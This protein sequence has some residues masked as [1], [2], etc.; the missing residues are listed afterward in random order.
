MKNI[1]ILGSS[2]MAGHVITKYLEE[3]NYN[4][5]GLSR[6]K[7][8][9]KNTIFI[10]LLNI[11]DFDKFLNENKFDFIINCAGILNQ[12]A[13]NKPDEAIFINSYVPRFLEKKY[14]NSTTKII[15]ISTD[16]V[17]SG[18]KG[19]YKEED[20]KDGDTIYARTKSLGELNNTKD[21]T[22]RTSIIGPD[23]N[24]NG[25]GLFNWFMHQKGKIKG[26]K[27]A[28]WTGIT[29]IEFAKSIEKALSQD[30]TGIYHL[31]PKNKINKFDLLNLINQIFEKNIEIEEDFNY[32]VDKSL[33][34]TR[35]DFDFEILDYDQMIKEMKIWIKN[36][37]EL[38]NY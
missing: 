27:E 8:I 19:N 2:G 15:H 35:N 11:K 22:F 26:F 4:V 31:V 25:I 38:Y 12:F 17:F 37:S 16:C 20:F 29:T 33:I 6:N 23:I 21:L 32:K 18:T 1:L 13:E 7:K 10:D 9:A 24:E 30:I 34:N 36:H 5:T 14:I 28:Y 3:K